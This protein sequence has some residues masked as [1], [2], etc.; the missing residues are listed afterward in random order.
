MIDLRY[1]EL[2]T[3]LVVD[4]EEFPI[5]TDFRRWMQFGE[6]VKAGYLDPCIW[7]GE[8][9]AGDWAPVATAFY[10]SPQPCPKSLGGSKVP[11][12]DHIIDGEMIVASFQASYGIDLT[13]PGLELHWHRYLALLRNLPEGAPESKAIGYRTY[14]KPSTAKD[15]HD[16][17]MRKLQ[18]A[19]ALPRASVYDE[20]EQAEALREQRAQLEAAGLI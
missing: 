13:D 7:P 11:A 4:G 19:Y 14:K 17:E 1:R 12:M 20:D 2:P 5:V 9:P 15:A 10:D 3:A 8:P 18:R 6:S 16:K